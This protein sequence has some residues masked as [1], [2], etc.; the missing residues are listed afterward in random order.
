MALVDSH[1]HFWRVSRGDY[2]WMDSAGVGAGIAALKRDFLPADSLPY[3]RDL[4]ITKAVLVQAANTTA[5]TEYILGIADA[6]P[7]IKAVVGWIDFLSPSS[8]KQLE[9]FAQHPKFVGVRPM[10]Q[11]ETDPLWLDRPD[12][13][14]AFD[15]VEEMGLTFDALGYPIH[16]APFA[17]LFQRKPNLR[18]V[19]DHGMKPLIVKREIDDWARD[20]AQ[21]ANETGV[22]CKFSGMITE[23]EAG[24]PLEVLVP[25]AKVLHDAFGTKRLMWGSDWPPVTLRTT[26]RDWFLG[27]QTLMP[28]SPD[29]FGANAERFYNI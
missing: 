14:W 25:Y 18:V 28:D 10:V 4:G 21:I 11:D 9:C 19:I 29:I 17:R 24:A 3:M 15:A 13:Q 12:I 27:A 22:M 16:L 2:F 5:E 26:Y 1:L 8:R 7:E 20:M 23:A 6:V